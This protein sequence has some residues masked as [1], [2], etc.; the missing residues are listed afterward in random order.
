MYYMHTENLHTVQSIQYILSSMLISH[1]ESH[2]INKIF[3]N[4]YLN[5]ALLLSP[6]H[7]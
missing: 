7:E 3:F 2:N 1:S 6:I 4:Y 5:N